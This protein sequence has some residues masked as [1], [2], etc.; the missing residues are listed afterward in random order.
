MPARR[1]NAVLAPTPMSSSSSV[2]GAADPHN[3]EVHAVDPD[4]ARLGDVGISKPVNGDGSPSQVVISGCLE[5]GGA[6]G[7]VVT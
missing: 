4:P 6:L 3:F 1:R 2:H 7:Q 5:H